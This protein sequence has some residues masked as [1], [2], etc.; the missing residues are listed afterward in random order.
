MRR[1]GLCS[2]LLFASLTTFA[3]TK[4]QSSESVPQWKVVKAISFVNQ[5]QAVPLT[6]LLTPQS[7]GVYQTEIYISSASES[8][9]SLTLSWT[10][11]ANDPMTLIEGLGAGLPNLQTHWIFSPLPGTPITYEISGGTGS[12][13][14]T[15]VIEKLG[16]LQ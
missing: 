15:V 6:A 14:Y 7:D 8:D 4:E 12:Y 13:N 10:D 16:N 1:L 11:L 9:W 2:F 5:T 3:Q